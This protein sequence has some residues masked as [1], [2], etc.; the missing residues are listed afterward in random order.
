MTLLTHFD[1]SRGAFAVLHK[2]TITS[3]AVASTGFDRHSPRN[4]AFGK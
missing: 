2:A 1:I 4:Y 3:P